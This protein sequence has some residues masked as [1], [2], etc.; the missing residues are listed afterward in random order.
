MSTALPTTRGQVQP[1]TSEDK[2][3]LVDALYYCVDGLATPNKH[4]KRSL[5]AFVADTEA[6]SSTTSSLA[7]P[8]S[9]SSSALPA[10]SETKTST[11]QPLSRKR[12][13][14]DSFVNPAVAM[15]L[16]HS[17][18][19]DPPVPTDPAQENGHLP[20]SELVGQTNGLVATKQFKSKYPTDEIVRLLLQ[21]LNVMGYHRAAQVLEEESHCRLEPQ[22]VLQFRQ[23]VLLGEW[24]Q[25]ELLLPKL[26]STQD[27]QSCHALFLL[28]KQKYLEHLEAG[29]LKQALQ[30]LQREL[31]TLDIEPVHLN[32]V[33]SLLMCYNATDLH[34]A[35]EWDGTNGVSRRRLLE[36]LEAYI[37]ADVM[38]PCGRL[39]TLFDQAIRDQG[40]RCSY[41]LGN[42]EPSLLVDHH[43]DASNFPRKVLHTLLG[44]DDE[45][46]LLAF[47]PDGTRLASGSKDCIVGIWDPESHIL[48]QQLKGHHRVITSLAWSPDGTQLLSGSHDHDVRLWNVESGQCERV[49][50]QHTQPTTACLWFPDG[51]RFIT[52]GQ[53]GSINIWDKSGERVSHIDGPRV[54]DIAINFE[55]GIMYVACNE[56]K[57]YVY[58]LE[59]GA[60]Q[61]SLSV[62]SDVATLLLLPSDPNLLLVCYTQGAMELWDTVAR[63]KVL[64]FMGHS[65]GNYV[66]RPCFVGS[67]GAYLACGSEDGRVCIWNRRT[68]KLLESLAGHKKTINT[69]AWH[70]SN[71]RQFATASD[72]KMIK[73]WGPVPP[74]EEVAGR[75]ASPLPVQTDGPAG[76]SSDTQDSP[77]AG[78]PLATFPRGESRSSNRDP[79]L[80]SRRSWLSQSSDR[81]HHP[82]DLSFDESHHVGFLV[83]GEMDDDDDED[84]DGG[85][86]ERG[87]EEDDDDEEPDDDEDEGDTDEDGN[88][89]AGADEGASEDNEP[90]QGDSRDP[91]DLM[92][93]DTNFSSDAES[94]RRSFPYYFNE[95]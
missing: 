40:S 90:G 67:D 13:R 26:L 42:E 54:H 41:H 4:P 93:E 46:W 80:I 52:G 38:V 27:T 8:P 20:S 63:Q 50:N 10:L 43:C 28:R 37:P 61:P 59:T 88:E 18:A 56:K 72:D 89:L 69:I 62:A 92:E 32:Q 70:P 83:V 21:Q 35:A 23:H 3:F 66:L 85:G 65:H 33:S 29:R 17:S 6:S 34:R 14:L 44:H 74:E 73:L 31:A 79:M 58:N 1:T 30:V 68:G 78:Y 60:A 9:P 11:D 64:S 45:V 5:A 77:N 49:I 57:L 19:P 94:I 2:R 47:S 22:E 71:A 7:Q 12:P 91:D 51:Q 24:P 15:Q 87:R 76:D 81:R 36:K 86:E 16:P 82:S 84:D 75:L 53:D 39:E 25:A 48:V 95:P 55:K